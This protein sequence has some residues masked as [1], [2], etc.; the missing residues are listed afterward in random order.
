MWST[1]KAI[2]LLPKVILGSL[3]LLL[4]L[5]LSHRNRYQS[6]S[7]DY[8]PTPR[9]TERP[10]SYRSQSV[11]RETREQ[12]NSEAEQTSQALAQFQSQE[13]Q[14]RAQAQDC[15]ARSN[16]AAAETRIAMMNGQ[17]INNQPACTQYMPQWT[18]QEA[19]LE[20]EIYRLQSGDRSS[21]MRDIVGIP[22][23]RQDASNG[24]SYYRPSSPSNDGGIGAVERWDRE[25]N[26]GTSLYNE[27]DGTQHELPTQSN[28]YRNP[29]SGEIIYSNQPNPPNDGR[30]WDR[31]TPQE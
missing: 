27:P 10:T 5:G 17:M 1:L 28:Y 6:T 23:P 25:V 3:L 20:T 18:A 15:M 8:E 14:L 16:Q 11:P 22:A 4:V 29:N 9:A 12:G 7:Y 24:P 26:R 21:S 30:Y 2:P 13:A 31:L 19:Y